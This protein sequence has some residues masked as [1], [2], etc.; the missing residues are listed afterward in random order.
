MAGRLA[1]IIDWPYSYIPVA[2]Y[3]S[4]FGSDICD[5][6]S[7]SIVRVASPHADVGGNAAVKYALASG[8][9]ELL[10][11]CADQV[12]PKDILKRF[13]SHNKPIVGALTA[14][15][16][17]VGHPWLLYEYTADGRFTQIEPTAKL[18]R[19]GYVGPGCMLVK[20]WVFK[21]LKPP[22]FYSTAAEDGCS[23]LMTNDFNFFSDAAAAGIEVYCDTTVVSDHLHEIALNAQSLGRDVG[24]IELATNE[25]NVALRS[26]GLFIPGGH[27]KVKQEVPVNG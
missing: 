14:S 6:V 5:E 4:I 9:D 11:V 21:K 1:V 27:C 19:C 18:Q 12:V 15:R 25:S 8:A 17:Q 22:W 3:M 23:I 2:H 10:F 26:Q 16:S 7:R 20:A 13:R 24:R